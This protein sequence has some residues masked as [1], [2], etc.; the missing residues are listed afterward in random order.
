[1]QKNAAARK[2]GA[3]RGAA[4]AE[5]GGGAARWDNAN[6]TVADPA[7]AHFD[8]GQERLMPAA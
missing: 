8:L 4:R 6:V 3:G 2:T 7:S 5:D 1:M